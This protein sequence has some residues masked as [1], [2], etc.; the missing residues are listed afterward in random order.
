MLLQ[1]AS[2]LPGRRCYSLQL[3]HHRFAAT[4]ERVSSTQF[5]VS[6]DGVLHRATVIVDGPKHVVFLNDH[7]YVLN[8]IDPLAFVV[9]A[10]IAQRAVRA[11]MPGRVIA[12]LASPGSR[13]SSGT[14]LLIIEAMKME[15]TVVAAAQGVLVAYKVAVGEQLQEGADLVDIAP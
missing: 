1:F 3:A 15:H 9:S 12:L 13:V 14:P 10:Q 2:A 4:C 8:F 7:R 6:L 5:R 11:P